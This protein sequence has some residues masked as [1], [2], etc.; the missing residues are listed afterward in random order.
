MTHYASS[1]IVEAND[2]VDSFTFDSS[3][4][5]EAAVMPNWIRWVES[6][7]V[8]SAGAVNIDVDGEYPEDAR[9]VAI[10]DLSAAMS[11][12]L[13][14]QIAQNQ[15]FRVK[16]VSVSLENRD[17]TIDNSESALFSGRLRWYSPTHHRVEAYQLYRSSWK[18]YYTASTNTLAFDD[19]HQAT[20]G[21]TYKGL[22]VGL[23]EST[24]SEQVPFQVLDPFTDVAG[25]HPNLNLI[26]NAYD[27]MLPSGDVDKKP[28]NAL[29]TSG[30]TGFPNSID[31]QTSMK[32]MGPNQMGADCAMFQ[33]NGDADVMCGLMCLDVQG[34]SAQG[35]LT[36]SVFTDEY[37]IRVTIGVEGW[38]GDF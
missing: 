5:G 4:F 19:E 1:K 38:G 12:H 32:N 10:I 9:P 37:K 18:A 25:I 21:G 30:R 3:G 34:S 11:H 23:I 15:T 7:Q 27:N 17:D 6:S 20:A 26:F 13:G 22:R 16:Y 36:D 14:R 35:D 2:T 31:W 28:D 33:W 24:A 8:D 29:W